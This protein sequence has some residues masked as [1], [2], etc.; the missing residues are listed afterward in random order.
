MILK[1]FL[2]LV[3]KKMAR[4]F[5]FLTFAAL[6]LLLLGDVAAQ[7]SDPSITL[8]NPPGGIS[9]T[10]LDLS[11]DS[12]T[13][14]PEQTGRANQGAS[15]TNAP[16]YARL[17]PVALGHDTSSH[18][19]DNATGND[20]AAPEA[21]PLSRRPDSAAARGGSQSLDATSSL[22][23]VGTSLAAV[24][25]I[26][27]ALA[28]LVR[29]NLPKGIQPPPGEVLEVLGRAPLPGKQ[30]LQVV[31]FG[32]KLVLLS[33]TTDGVEAVSE[34]TEP[35][36]VQQLTALCRRQ[37]PGSSAHAFQEILA[38]MGREPA[39]GFLDQRTATSTSALR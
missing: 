1:R 4:A 10:T 16:R 2:N 9:T 24:L 13:T 26:F 23:T 6:P 34:I 20:L 36:E 15:L 37:T 28:Y 14:A 8:G 35:D 32:S 22:V 12:P 31:R 25:G 33:V 19:A 38:Q 21:I 39:R 29:R 5:H 18:E 27:F 3:Q 7:E 11:E 30:Q 17:P